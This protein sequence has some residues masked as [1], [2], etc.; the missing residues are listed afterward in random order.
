MSQTYRLSIVNLEIFPIIGVYDS[1]RH[2]SQKL[3]LT[4]HITIQSALS[5][6]DRLSDTIDYDRLSQ[7]IVA[8]SATTRFQLIETLGYAIC[9]RIF[10]AHSSILNVEIE[11]KKFALPNA[12]YVEFHYSFK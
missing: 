2:A 4:V 9:E 8:F 6:T 12:E 7:E 5:Q 10:N 1:E 11:L 3:L